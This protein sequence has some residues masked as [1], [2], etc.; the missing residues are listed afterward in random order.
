MNWNIKPVW[1]AV[2]GAFVF[3]SGYPKVVCFVAGFASC[4]VLKA[5]V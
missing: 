1:E 4:A 3:A 2:K 5:F